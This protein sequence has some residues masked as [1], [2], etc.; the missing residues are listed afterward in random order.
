MKRVF[1]TVGTTSFDPFVESI[2]SLPFLTATLQCRCASTQKPPSDQPALS[3]QCTLDQQLLWRSCEILHSSKSSSCTQL[4]LGFSQHSS[5]TDP[6]R[7]SE[8]SVVEVLI[9][10]G[11]GSCPSQFLPPAVGGAVQSDASD[12]EGFISAR[13][14]IDNG[15]AKHVTMNIKW[16][17]FKTS[18]TADMEGAD[19]ILC[20]AGAGT[21][22]EALS[23]K[24]TND[25]VINAV[26][27][28]ELMDNH[29][30]E[31]ADELEKR[32]HIR[33]TKEVKELTTFSGARDFWT[34]VNDFVPKPFVDGCGMS[35]VDAKVSNFQRI[36]DRVMS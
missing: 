16:Y 31:L 14:P 10:Y 15:A 17:R 3:L 28:S 4:P 24:S 26:I 32:K 1:A 20:H 22:L 18:L 35:Q 7:E 36:I 5:S 25:R 2:C 29:Q 6:D 21:L 27:N 19:L 13:F 23:L 12:D 11:M 34:E 33:V 9:Q 8:E 30:S